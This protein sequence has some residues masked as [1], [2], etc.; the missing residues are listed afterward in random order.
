M[1]LLAQIEDLSKCFSASILH[2][3]LWHDVDG[4]D[5][6]FLLEN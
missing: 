3:F 4:K 2:L 1:K 6:E 5:D